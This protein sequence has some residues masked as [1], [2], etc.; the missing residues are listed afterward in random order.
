MA[1]WFVSKQS[2]KV[3][4]DRIR[5]QVVHRASGFTEIACTSKGSVFETIKP[6]ERLAAR[7]DTWHPQ[8][9]EEVHRSHADCS[10]R[11]RP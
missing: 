4:T 3:L 9:L 1:R 6:A 11:T 7:T 5:L 2:A 10:E 8:L